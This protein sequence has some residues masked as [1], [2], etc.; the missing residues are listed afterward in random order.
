MVEIINIKMNKEKAILKIGNR[1]V[2]NHGIVSK[3]SGEINNFEFE[4]I[5]YN[6][7]YQKT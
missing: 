4:N 6:L 2:N 3:Y 1:R 7:I 5:D